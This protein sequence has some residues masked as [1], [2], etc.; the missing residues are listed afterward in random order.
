[1]LLS[2]LENFGDFLLYQTK[3]VAYIFGKK[4]LIAVSSF[5]Y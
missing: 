2:C 4:R 5:M 1:M 3:N